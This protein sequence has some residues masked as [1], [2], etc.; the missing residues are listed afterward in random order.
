MTKRLKEMKKS[1]ILFLFV[2]CLGAGCGFPLVGSLTL[3]DLRNRIQELEKI[4][5]EI[6]AK[7]QQLNA[8]CLKYE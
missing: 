1:A 8:M 6:D 7:L 3:G 4:H 2:F 5:A